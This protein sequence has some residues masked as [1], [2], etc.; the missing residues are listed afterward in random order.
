MPIPLVLSGGL[1]ASNVAEAIRQIRPWAVD[2]S[3][4]VEA[5]KGVKDPGR[6]AQFIAGVKHG[7]DRSAV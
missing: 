7:D 3:S 2:V 1:D 6:I 5:A 4:G